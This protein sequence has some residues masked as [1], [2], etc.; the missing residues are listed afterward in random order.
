MPD[1]SSETRHGSAS[2]PASRSLATPRN[3]VSTTT[4]ATTTSA[5]AALPDSSSPSSGTVVVSDSYWRP[6]HDHM[7]S[8]QAV[9]PWK[10]TP[11]YFHDV[12][13]TVNAVV[14]MFL[15]AQRGRPGAGHMH[16]EW[17]EV[18]GLLLGHY[19][20]GEM[21]IT[22]SF[23][24]PV[25]ASEVECS[26]NESSQVYMANIL[27]YHR[28]LGKA[29]KGCIGWY[30]THPGYGCFLS[31]I[32]VNTQRESQMVQDP[33]VAVVIDP[34]ATLATGSFVMKAFRTK[35]A[36]TVAEKTHDTQQTTHLQHPTSS[37]SASSSLPTVA[38]RPQ[39]GSIMAPERSSEFGAHAQQYYELP[40]RVVQSQ[41]DA[42]LMGLLQCIFWPQL[43]S[44]TLPSSPEH[45]LQEWWPA[46]VQQC[47]QQLRRAA[48]S[49]R[50]PPQGSTYRRELSLPLAKPPSFPGTRDDDDGGA[51]DLNI[52]D[53]KWCDKVPLLYRKAFQLHRGGGVS[54]MSQQ[55][56]G[57]GR[58]GSGYGPQ[59]K[60]NLSLAGR[61]PNRGA[62]TTTITK[63]PPRE[64]ERFAEIG[65]RLTNLTHELLV[66]RAARYSVVAP[67]PPSVFAVLES[68]VI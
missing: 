31:G 51:Y 60:L 18:M 63:G 4:S 66:C 47:T 35:P 19:K 28:R 54:R 57:A 39:L 64:D 61:P 43:L 14:K 21:V 23:S 13:I 15:H 37:A 6:D 26:M 59:S 12:S 20:D 2:Q 50:L 3:T 40:M 42:T 30:H 58:Y 56:R 1:S 38:S 29:E 49:L 65:K 5:V 17:F 68:G 67:S 33:W 45:L 7:M 34:V 46:E 36:T 9:R 22:D 48:L 8:M 24:V 55:G 32:D 11:L 53:L 62:A 52:D 10:T 16:R 44:G 25:D 27:N 41:M